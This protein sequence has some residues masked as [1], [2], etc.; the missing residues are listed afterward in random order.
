MSK[1]QKKLQRKNFDWKAKSLVSYRVNVQSENK[2][3]MQGGGERRFFKI[4][5][6]R[7]PKAH[8]MAGISFLD[9]MSESDLEYSIYDWLSGL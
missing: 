6:E 5:R 3:T 8:V 9:S 7:L 4:L 1:Q 2:A